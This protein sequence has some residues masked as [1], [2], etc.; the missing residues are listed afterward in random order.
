[1][2]VETF[3]EDALVCTRSWSSKVIFAMGLVKLYE[4]D[5]WLTRWEDVVESFRK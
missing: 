3:M 1:M 2:G 5:Y 4:D